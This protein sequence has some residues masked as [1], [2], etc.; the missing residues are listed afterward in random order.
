[1][2]IIEFF[3]HLFA[4]HFVSIFLFGLVGVL[5]AIIYFLVFALFYD[6]IHIN[7]KV[8]VTIAYMASVILHFLANRSFT[9]KDRNG[10]LSLHLMKY[11]FVLLTNYCI[12][13][14]IVSYV[15]GS[16]LLSPYIGILISIITTASS[17]YLLLRF[18]VFK[19]YVKGVKNAY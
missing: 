10:T 6:V 8:A 17:G 16:L 5:S 7:Y 12:T 4:T 2:K 9:F 18:W 19:V 14:L 1:M 13:L 11:L 15:V 3:K